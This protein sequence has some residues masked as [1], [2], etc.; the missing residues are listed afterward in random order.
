MT[1]NEF[2]NTN[3]YCHANNNEPS[4]QL[5]IDVRVQV[6]FQTQSIYLF[7]VK[8]KLTNMIDD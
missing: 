7:G 6:N 5:I 1:E 8:M 3:E 4:K 2:S